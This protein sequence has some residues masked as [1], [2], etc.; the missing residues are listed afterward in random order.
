MGIWYEKV[1]LN[2]HDN[3]KGA[4]SPSLFFTI[5]SCSY[6]I[7]YNSTNMFICIVQLVYLL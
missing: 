2:C 6:Y 4:F 5:L 3:T 1:L 7:S